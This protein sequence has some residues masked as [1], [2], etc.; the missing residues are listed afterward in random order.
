MSLANNTRKHLVQDLLHRTIGRVRRPVARIILALG[1]I[2]VCL[3]VALIIL[4]IAL[5]ND[6]K[7]AVAIYNENNWVNVITTSSGKE[8]VGCADG[9]DFSYIDDGRIYPGVSINGVELGGMDY[10]AARQALIPAVQ[11]L[12]STVNMSVAVKNACL[13]LTATDFKITT[14][15]NE[16]IYKALEIGRESVNDYKSNYDTQQRAASEGIDFTIDCYMDE[17][18]VREKISDVAEFVNTEPTEP[19]ITINKR[20]SANSDDISSDGGS[21]IASGSNVRTVYADNG[22]AIADMV[23]NEGSS[24]YILNEEAMLSQIIAAFNNHQYTT[25]IAMELEET[26]PTGTVEALKDSI[27]QLTVFSTTFEDSGFNR[28]RNVQKGAGIINGM[29]L[30]PDEE[31]SF[32]DYVGPRTEAGGWLPAAGISGGKE[33]VDSPG[34]GICQVSTTL[35]NALLL[36]GPDIEMVY[37]QHHSWPSTYVPYGLDATVDT[38]GPDFKWKNVSDSPMYVFAYANTAAGERII[39]VYVFGVPDAEGKSYKVW[40]ETVDEIK[41]GEALIINEPLWPSGYTKQT[42]KERT[43]YKAIV[44]RALCDKDG[45]QIGDA[46]VLYQDYYSPVRGEIH[47]GTGAATLPKPSN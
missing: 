10:A 23:F 33:Y 31:I 28:R 3:C 6:H 41:P 1:G 44:Y 37:R 32:N 42:I 24:G 7:K 34:G 13:V 46:E 16:L 2:V 35:Y 26:E 15:V 18:S 8:I 40:A 4:S 25:E 5:K 47:V 22:V 17:D 9:I 14:N 36:V 20:V 21:D 43:G 12:L 27:T 19:Y 39:S 45:N 30:N 29:I 11:E 38:Y